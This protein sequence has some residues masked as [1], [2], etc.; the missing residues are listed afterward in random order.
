MS[1]DGKVAMV[2][3]G[4]SGL[5]LA[6]AKELTSLGARVVITGRR[7]QQLDDAVATRVVAGALADRSVVVITTPDADPADVVDDAVGTSEWERFRLVRGALADLA[8]GRRPRHDLSPFRWGRFR[9][10]RQPPSS[11]I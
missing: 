10:F 1:F 5:G 4:S 8:M 11:A 7:Q 2:T 6:I 9:R 3:G